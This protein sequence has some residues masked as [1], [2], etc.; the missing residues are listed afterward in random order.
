MSPPRPNLF[1]IGSMKS[2]TTYLSELLGEHPAIFMCS[3]KEPGYFVDPQDL[4]RVWPAAREAGYLRSAES[5]LSLFAPAGDAAIVAEASTSYSQLP[6]F[7]GVPERIL[8]F[9]PQARFIYIMRDP[10]ERAISHYWQRVRWGVERRPMLSAI[11]AEPHYRD[12]SHYARQLKAYL[13][14]L[15]RARI[16]LLTYEA[17]LADPAGQ[18]SRVYAWLGVDPSFRPACLGVPNNVLP[19]A[20]EQVRGLGWLHRF[21]QSALYRNV[22]PRVPRSL[23]RLGNR[24][25]LRRVRPA[26]VDASVVKAYLR[27]RLQ[28]ETEELSRLLG[29]GFP[30]WRTLYAHDALGTVAYA[31]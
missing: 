5:Y 18:L 12:V 21:S 1:L 17:L 15:E 31:R 2:G 30:E 23:R 9:S 28:L 8:A 11:C 29:R 3:P 22:A 20:V 16:Y 25:A 14:H 26:E 27:P 24:L 7:P 10:V 4:L 6:L 13:Q 19:E